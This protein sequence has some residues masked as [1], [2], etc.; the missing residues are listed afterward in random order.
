MS[1]QPLSSGLAEFL[2]PYLPIHDLLDTSE[3]IVTLTYAQ[4]LD[5]R[6]SKG[7][8]VR[9]TISHPETKTMTHYLRY[10]HDGI[11]VGTGTV[12]ADDPGLNCKFGA[13]DCYEHS[14]R[15][16]IIDCSQKWKFEGSKMQQLYLLG[17]GKS[18]IVVV[19]NEP[20]LREKHV[21]Y[22]ICSPNEAGKLDWFQ[23]FRTLRI[24][25]GLR[26]IMVEGGASVIN[27]LL[28]RPDLVN[29]LII[30]IGS[31]FLGKAGVEVSPM[32]ATT[33]C[34]VDWWKGLSDA[35]LAANLTIEGS[36]TQT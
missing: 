4:S 29:N 26:S 5:S 6:I 9:T 30:T 36:G 2:A 27:Q 28:L 32:R 33:L 35:V 18:P 14:P 20:L 8:G 25:F 7:H 11:L 16:I 3:T 23:L 10:H 13:T 24:R 21:E 17:E 1:I 31:T 34:N 19:A 15:P 12:L 22:L